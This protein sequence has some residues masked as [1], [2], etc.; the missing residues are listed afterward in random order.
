MQHKFN[1]IHAL[2]LC[3]PIIC[4]FHRAHEDY[5]YCQAGTSGTMFDDN[6]II[7]GAPGPFTWRGTV[8]ELSVDDDYL[9]RDK[10]HYYGPHDEI[11]SPVDKYSYLG[12]LYFV[13]VER[14]LL[15]IFSCPPAGMAVTGGRFY[16]KENM[17]YA[18]GAPRSS[19]HG[20]VVI[21]SKEGHANPMKVTQILDGL[22]FASSFGYE[23]TTADINGDNKADLIVAAPFYFS[24]HA[25]GAVYVYQNDNYR[26]PLLPTTTLTGK[27][28]SH[29]G[30]A[31]ANLGD[32]NKDECDD[33]AVGAP[34][35]D[36]GVVY[37]YLGSRQGL[38]AVPSQVIRVSDLGLK[39]PRSLSTFGSSLAGGIDVDG[40]TYNDLVVGAYGS[41]TVVTLLGRKIMN[42]ETE[43]NALSLR[44][45]VSDRSGCAT[46][47]GTNLTCF[48][49]RACCKISADR[50]SVSLN[51]TIEAEMKRKFSR[52]F[53]G[54]DFTSRVNVV[55][56]KIEVLTN[57]KEDCREHTVYVKENTRDI[58]TPIEVSFLLLL[59][60]LHF[61]P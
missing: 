35:E 52:V 48:V 18:A 49:L 1:D 43:V 40:N 20:Q 2:L 23:L 54:P 60:R 7:L 42:I 32:M 9:K 44:N 17:S 16:S 36:D 14:F 33:L 21:F 22:Q 45:I 29:F 5:S 19:G 12:K 56:Q 57:G 55:R 58:Q 47:P 11:N 34:Y 24:R 51:Y 38:S 46:D 28:E 61:Y 59:L 13:M 6:T 3:D 30:L 27:H 53:F 37:I 50:I 4:D 10:S 25:G 31:V 26:L 41:A 39:P 15:L 8:Y